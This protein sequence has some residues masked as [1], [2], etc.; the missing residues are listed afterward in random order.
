MKI[1]VFGG[2]GSL[3]QELVFHLE[4]YHEV[5]PL[6]RFNVDIIDLENVRNI[7]ESIK[8]D[9][10]INTVAITHNIVE[11]KIKDQIIYETNVDGALNIATTCKNNNIPLIHIS[12]ASVIAGSTNK[13]PEAKRKSIDIIGES[14]L[15][16]EIMIEDIFKD[17]KDK[18]YLII[19]LG[20]L[21]GKYG[22]SIVNTLERLIKKNIKIK[23]IEDIIINL[24]AT[25]MVAEYIEK[26]LEKGISSLNKKI[27]HCCHKKPLS[28]YELAEK[29]SIFIEKEIEIIRI[30][31]DQV[32]KESGNYSLEMDEEI[33]DLDKYL[34]DFLK[35]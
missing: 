16:A 12:C 31:A 19:R 23:V 27:I 4:E 24:S 7:I 35:G 33:G 18:N 20:V 5:I 25:K 34:K 17:T 3:G 32:N 9:I 8:P 22:Y 28:Y 30:T 11:N 29:I 14:K 15:E 1:I 2:Q 13:T 21:F 6:S 10:I 26:I